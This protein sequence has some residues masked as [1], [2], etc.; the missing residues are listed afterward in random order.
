MKIITIGHWKSSSC[1]VDFPLE[2]EN[3][4]V[5]EQATSQSNSLNTYANNTIALNNKMINNEV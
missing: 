5:A 1:K 4:S 3:F 2:I